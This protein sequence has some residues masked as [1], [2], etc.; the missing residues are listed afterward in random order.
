MGYR[1]HVIKKKEEFSNYSAFN[2]GY[3]DFDTLLVSLKVKKQIINEDCDT[4]R[5]EVDRK[6]IQTAKDTL[7][8]IS[9]GENPG[10][11]YDVQAIKQN[12]KQLDCTVEEMAN[13]FN[14]FLTES[15]PE[16]DE[17]ILEWF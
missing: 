6:E 11:Q 16:G 13:V 7:V 14:T 9:R 10:E 15:D 4:S 1:I 17:I 5:Y 12:I 2:H 3:D 8:A